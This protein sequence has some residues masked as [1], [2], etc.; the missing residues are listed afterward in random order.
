[1]EGAQ[2]QPWQAVSGVGPWGACLDGRDWIR[3]RTT[4][5]PTS[6]YGAA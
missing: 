3:R 4:W 2:R 1:M 5:R 6:R